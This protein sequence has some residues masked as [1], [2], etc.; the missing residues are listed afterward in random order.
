[1]AQALAAVQRRIGGQALEYLVLGARTVDPDADPVDQHR[2]AGID[3]D[4]HVPVLI[5]VG[6]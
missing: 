3:R 6:T 4:L 5:L 2:H 1:V